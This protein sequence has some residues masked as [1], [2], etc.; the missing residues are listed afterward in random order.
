MRFL[1]AVVATVVLMG[2][3]RGQEPTRFPGV[4]ADIPTSRQYEWLAN[5][6][7]EAALSYLQGEDGVEAEQKKANDWYKMSDEYWKEVYGAYTAEFAYL[8][9]NMPTEL[10]D[11]LQENLQDADWYFNVGKTELDYA[12]D[13]WDQGNVYM[14]WGNSAYASGDYY[15]AWGYYE[16]ATDCYFNSMYAYRG[17]SSLFGEFWGKA[18]AADYLMGL[19]ID[20]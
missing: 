11:I 7:Y 9:Q 13:C 14:N 12:F 1:M 16:C 2:V 8:Y 3:G 4:P 19:Y 6:Q 20:R 10:W 15:S 18:V 5:K 17:A